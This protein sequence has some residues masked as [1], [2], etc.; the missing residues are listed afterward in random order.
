VSRRCRSSIT[1]AQVKAGGAKASGR[2]QHCNDND[3]LHIVEQVSDPGVR[4][5]LRRGNV[6]DYDKTILPREIRTCCKK[7]SV[8][9]QAIGRNATKDHACRL[10]E[11][12]V[13]ANDPAGVDALARRSR[14]YS[15]SV[16]AGLRGHGQGRV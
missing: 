2:R 6:L 11:P 10:F 5:T 16:T 14:E 1:F 9:Q 15:E 8:P 13:S 3:G 7:I 4:I 12:L